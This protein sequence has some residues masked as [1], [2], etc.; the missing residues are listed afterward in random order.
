MAGSGTKGPVTAAGGV[1]T[2]SSPDH[3]HDVILVFRGGH[4][5]WSLPKGKLDSG[6]SEVDCAVREV[7]EETGVE[8]LATTRLDSVHY[9]LPNG[10][11]KTVHFWLMEVKG[12]LPHQLETKDPSE[13]SRVEWIPLDKAISLVTYQSDRNVLKQA[14]ELLA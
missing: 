9:L 12:T 4:N 2:K 14:K 11:E 13:V 10:S 5:D 3:S 8:V 7:T 6:E 1:V